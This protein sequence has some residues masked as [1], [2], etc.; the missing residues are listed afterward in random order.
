MDFRADALSVRIS[1]FAD[2]ENQA[3]SVEIE[4]RWSKAEA[5]AVEGGMDHSSSLAHQT[6]V[7]SDD[8]KPVVTISEPYLRESQCI[9]KSFSAR[10]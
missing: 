7:S 1:D 3:I 10:G 5:V 9:L 2:D 6:E 4:R 8:D